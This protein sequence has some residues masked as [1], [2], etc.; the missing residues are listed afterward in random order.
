MKDI[1]IVFLNGETFYP[2]HTLYGKVVCRNT[3]PLD[4]RSTN[5]RSF[6]ETKVYVLLN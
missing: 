4:L 2:G 6:Y 1:T 3:N 5:V